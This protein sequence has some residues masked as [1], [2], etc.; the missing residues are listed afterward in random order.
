MNDMYGNFIYDLST[1]YL[2]ILKYISYRCK[3]VVILD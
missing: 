1:K 2:H 3:P